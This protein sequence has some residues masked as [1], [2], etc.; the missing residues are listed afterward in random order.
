[1]SE[2]NAQGKPTTKKVSKVFSFKLSQKDLA[3]KAVLLGELHSQLEAAERDLAAAKEEYK[4]TAAGIAVERSAAV[5]AIRTG[6]EYRDT[7]CEEVHDFETNRV[8]WRRPSEVASDMWEMLEER[9]MTPQERQL[10][11]N[12]SDK[13]GAEYEKAA[14]QEPETTDIVTDAQ[15]QALKE[16]QAQA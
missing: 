15:V 10:A 14:Q 2:E 3:N 1:M 6:K 12:L 13:P 5:D 8:Y 16:E 7:E 11:L 9:A 4:S